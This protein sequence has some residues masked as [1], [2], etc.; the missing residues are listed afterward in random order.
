MD[1]SQPKIVYS[2]SDFIAVLNHTLEYAYPNVEIEGEISTYKVNQ[3]KY[4]FFDIKDE[5]GVLNCFMTVWQVRTPVEI[6]MKVIISAAPKITPNGKFSLTVKA[7]RPSG[8]G[9]I[10]KSFELLKSRLEKEGLFSPERKRMLPR[11]P[12]NIALISSTQAAGYADF[13]KIIN[14]RWGGI[15]IQVAQVQV[16]GRDSPDQIINAIKFFNQQQE[17]ADVL[18]IIS[19]GGSAE[20]LSGFNDELLVRE[21]AASRI[22]VLIGVGHV[23]DET[24]SDLAADY[25]AAT[26][27]N[28]AQVLVPD[29]NEII[30]S[31]RF[32]V[33][34]IIPKL[35]GILSKSINEVKNNN[36]IIIKNIENSIEQKL[37][38]VENLKNIL[39]QLNPSNILQRGY[40]IIRG[41]VDVGR[42]IEIETAT[43]IIETEV[44][45]V[46][47]K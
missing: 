6:G 45:N 5:T 13:I 34:S 11:I 23:T 18:V 12:N 8:E 46:I 1:E 35:D 28:A 42:E 22:P 21:I 27:S 25:S 10:K 38:Q 20:D 26:P 29:R 33:K 3:N 32:L 36:L 41:V 15:K 19:G 31:V 14:D 2:V 17:V 7:I 24:L 43:K 47:N 30:R 16:Q 40:A 44:K 4:V 39:N 37:T 9:A